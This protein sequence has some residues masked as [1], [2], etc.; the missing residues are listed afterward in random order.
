MIEPLTLGLAYGGFGAAQSLLGFSSAQQQAA[1]QNNAL[2]DDYRQRLRIQQLQ[3]T[4]RFNEYNLKVAS[5]KNRLVNL[6]KTY[7]LEN[8][9]AQQTLNQLEKQQR[10]AAQTE[11]INRVQA[12]GKIAA[13]GQQG[14]SAARGLALTSAEFGRRAA[15]RQER[16]LGEYQAAELRADA[17]TLGLAA[18]QR[19]A[20]DR[21]A[22]A[23]VPTPTP[24]A[25]TMYQGPSAAGLFANLIGNALGGLSA[26]VGQANYKK[27]LSSGGNPA[28]MG[29]VQIGQAAR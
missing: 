21:V 18:A 2:I 10:F 9:Q 6:N 16:M 27:Q 24:L 8:V 11:N 29:A 7:N 26:A 13:G 28:D 23:P 20:H 4:T 1:Q 17:R 12:L 25:P 22:F 3:D 15:A 5:Y 19:A 14:A